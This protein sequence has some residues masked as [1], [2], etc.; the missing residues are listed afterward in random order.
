[1]LDRTSK[2]LLCLALVGRAAVAQAPSPRPDAP[3]E[4]P[5]KQMT[6]TRIPTG[7][8]AI[9]L[10]GR[11]DDPAW[12]GAAW[13]ADF[14]QKMPH[15]GAA[16]TDSMRIAILYDEDALYVGARIF[17][18]TA[19]RIQA[20]LS[21]RDNTAQAEHLWVSFDTYH[22][23]RTAYSFGVTASGVRMDWYHPRDNE[24]DLDA[25]FD[26]VWEARAVIDS[27][28]WTAE[29][30]IPFSQLR[31]NDLPVQVWGFNA[32]HWNPA[33]SEDVFW[34]PVPTNRTGWSSWMGELDGITGIKPARRMELVPY[35]AGNAT[36]TGARDPRDPF[37]DGKNLE[38]R[39]GADLK[40]GLGPNMT[41]D[42]TVNPDF[43][44]VEA[45]PAVVN[46]SAFE[47]FFDEKRPF[48]TEGSQLL[49]GNGPSYFYSRR[50]GATP[51]GDAAGDFV[52]Y[53]H[54]STILG[55]AKVTGRLAS[56]LS[57][58]ALTA[59]TGRE[60]ARTVSFDT[61][62]GVPT[63]GR[64]EVAPASGYGVA[65][66]QQEFGPNASVVGATLTGVLRDEAPGSAVAALYNREAFAGGLDAVLRWNRGLYQL[67]GWIGFSRIGGDAAAIDRVQRS[68]VH[69]FQRPDADYVRYDSTRTAL[70]GSI[71]N[72]QFSKTGGHWLYSGGAGWESPGYDPNDAG[73]LGNADGRFGYLDLRYN[74]TRPTR[75]LQG[76]HVGATLDAEWDFGGDRQ[77]LVA[78][79]N[80]QLT[81]KNFWNFNA[82]FDYFPGSFDH[83]ATRGGPTMATPSKRNVAVRLGNS[84]GARTAWN[85]RLSYSWDVLGG[86]SYR[87]SGGLSIRPGARWQLS[88]NPNYQR[89]TEPRQYIDSAPGGRAATYGTR[90][91]FSFIDQSTF[92]AQ[93]R[94]N[95]TVRPDLTIDVYAEPFAA[96]GR[97]YGIGELAAART[98]DLQRYAVDSTTRD[99][100]GDYTFVDA[101]DTIRVANPDFNVLSFRSNLVVRWEWRAGSTLYLVWQQS[102]G[103]SDTRG[104]LVGPGDLWDSLGATGDNFLAIK[105]S[106]W[107]PVK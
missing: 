53:P 81:F 54:N 4:P 24:Y 75:R 57:V 17:R 89:Q 10:D 45:D 99:A 35:S 12:A 9:H 87:L 25:G 26:P 51:R 42:A 19:S 6:A 79:A 59:V 95:Y 103:A 49:R 43:G 82:T 107:I 70:T 3:V 14:V 105:A 1:V 64:V 65:R 8:S 56:G 93:L 21:R 100:Q 39:G 41:L 50:I 34:I 44:Q 33:T 76:Y 29:M 92:G 102:R 32:D 16:P 28:G 2:T 61:L 80:A 20:P 23:R 98:F 46:L 37:D 84:F 13:I 36:V 91:L 73:R 55:A 74:E 62:S 94:L 63:F 88:L 7:G 31:F 5:H 38:A 85:G 22:D 78:E 69:F 86:Q 48:F 18:R 11:L 72:L 68:A 67:Q 77:F 30:R 27:A 15:E 96:S 97:Y 101:G 40:M 104:R 66:V 106:Y 47:V 71:A 58:G 52:D 90:Y 83:S 60:T